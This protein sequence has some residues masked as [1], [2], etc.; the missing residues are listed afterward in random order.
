TPPEVMGKVFSLMMTAMT[1]AMPVGLLLAGPV[2]ELVG[3]D[4]WFFWSGAALVVTGLL[5]RLMTRR[6]DA[7][8][9][10]P[11]APA[12]AESKEAE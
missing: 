9:M 3:V 12:P 8:T 6:Y 7:Q 11:E 2:T 5:C 1:L 10:L 4:V